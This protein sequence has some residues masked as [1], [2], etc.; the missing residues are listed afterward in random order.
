MWRHNYIIGRNEYLISIL[1][2]STF[3]WVYS[4]QFSF[5][6]THH[7]W[8]YERKCEWVFFSEHSVVSFFKRGVDDTLMSLPPPSTVSLHLRSVVSV[9]IMCLTNYAR[10]ECVYHK[11]QIRTNISNHIIAYDLGRPLNVTS[12]LQNQCMA[13]ISADAA[14]NMQVLQSCKWRTL[15]LVLWHWHAHVGSSPD[16]GLY[17]SWCN[18]DHSQLFP[19]NKKEISA[20][21]FEDILM[22]HLGSCL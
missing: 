15:C 11:T 12:L 18:I 16:N 9:S 7:S 13:N 19:L 10:W 14:Y 4:L 17:T 22:W 21:H 3:P 1:L 8:R 2:E 5:K 20:G 6:S